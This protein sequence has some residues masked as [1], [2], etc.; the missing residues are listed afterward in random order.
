[1]FH[2][3]FTIK[4]WNCFCISLVSFYVP[5]TIYYYL[6]SLAHHNNSNSLSKFKM[7]ISQKNGS[8]L[9]CFAIFAI[10]CPFIL[11]QTCIHCCK[12]SEIQKITTKSLH[13]LTLIS[14]IDIFLSFIYPLCKL[15][16][17]IKFISHMWEFNT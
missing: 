13:K 4:I 14:R 9:N 15:S 10:I 2:H 5:L 17:K 7:T 11:F 16:K 12:Y 3:P 1:L 8:I 6:C